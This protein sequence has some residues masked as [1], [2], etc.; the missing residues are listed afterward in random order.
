MSGYDHTDPRQY[1]EGTESERRGPRG[2]GDGMEPSASYRLRRDGNGDGV[3][4]DDSAS[5]DGSVGFEMSLAE[6][7]YS[8]SSFYAIVVPGKA[9]RGNVR[10][11]DILCSTRLF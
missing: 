9:S 5:D 3:F 11:A 10:L 7:L 1:G 2:D 6:L 4:R 8:T